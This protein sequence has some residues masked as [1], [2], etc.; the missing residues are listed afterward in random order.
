MQSTLP[1]MRHPTKQPSYVSSWMAS[2]SSLRN[3][4]HYTATIMP[5][6]ALPR[7]KQVTPPSNTFGSNFIL[8]GNLLRKSSSGSPASNLLRTQPTFLQ[9]SWQGL[10]SCDCSSTWAFAPPYSCLPISHEEEHTYIILPLPTIYLTYFTHHT[11]L[12]LTSLYLLH[13][14]LLPTHY[15]HTYTS[16]TLIGTQLR[17]SVRM[18]STSHNTQTSVHV[19]Y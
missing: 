2:A 15:L 12:Y 16:Y 7:I 8:S 19:M 4:P 9:N 17:R 18:S 14:R 3:L 6:L 1:C 13:H 10:I 5:L 11:T